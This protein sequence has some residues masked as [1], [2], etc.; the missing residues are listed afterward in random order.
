MELGTLGYI[1]PIYDAIEKQTRYKS[2]CLNVC[3]FKLLYPLNS[4]PPFQLQ[5][6]QST[7][8]Y[9]NIGDVVK[10]WYLVCAE[11]DSIKADLSAWIS[12]YM[13]LTQYKGG[14]EFLTYNG[15]TP[16][17]VECGQY[18]MKLSIAEAGSGSTQIEYFS[19][20][21]NVVDAFENISFVQS[22]FPLWSL[23]RWYDD[24]EKQTRN[25]NNCKS[26]CDFYLNCGQDA[27]LPFQF[28]FQSEDMPVDI[29][30]SLIAVDGSCEISIGD[31]SGITISIVGDYYY[32]TYK[33]DAFD[34]FTLPCGKFYLK[35]IITAGDSLTFYSELI[36]IDVSVNTPVTN[37]I[38][39][40]NGWKILLENGFGLLQ[41]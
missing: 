2:N 32:V 34:N 28:R 27:L 31:I 14:Y 15:G 23:W 21:F 8:Y 7:W 16:V 22:D 39:Q 25:K 5:A 6:D 12:T 18:Y 38:L 33:G 10:H 20:A 30:W 9:S 17:N 37:Y 19:E 35:M 1:L 13:V 4:L 40:E 36:Y 11:D 41:E 26:V 29:E 24:T 3:E